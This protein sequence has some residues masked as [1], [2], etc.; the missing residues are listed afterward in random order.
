MKDLIISP[1]VR[2]KIEVAMEELYKLC[3]ANNVPVVIGV[4]LER[5]KESNSAAIN[6]GVSFFIDSRTGA[7]D[8]SLAAACEMLK[9]D[10]VPEYLI[11]MMRLH[12]DLKSQLNAP[13][14]K[15]NAPE[16]IH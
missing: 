11:R 6:K 7:Y 9:M 1:E 14:S 13:A 2:N 3:E 15:D 10:S 12:N 5:M 8:S 4:L 16:L